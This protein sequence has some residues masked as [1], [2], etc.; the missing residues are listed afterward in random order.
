MEYRL[1]FNLE[2]QFRSCYTDYLLRALGDQKTI[3]K[4]CPC[5]KLSHPVTY[6]D[7][8]VRIN[9]RLLPVEV[10]LNIAME[11]NLEG[12]CVQYCMLDQMIIN[13]NKSRKYG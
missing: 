7:N 13:T 11:S 12:Q 1:S 2:I 4:E 3:F 10:K 5:Y 6:V 8:V 9:K